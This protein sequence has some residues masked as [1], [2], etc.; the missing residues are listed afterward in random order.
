MSGFPLPRLEDCSVPLNNPRYTRSYGDNYID[1][2]IVGHPGDI[3]VNSFVQKAAYYVPNRPLLKQ[4]LKFH[5]G[6]KP[7]ER[8]GL[9]DLVVHI[10]LTDYATI[11]NYPG[12]EVFERGVYSL[13]GQYAKLFI[14]TDDP[15]DSEIIELAR[16][17]KG[18]IRRSSPKEDFYFLMNADYLM[19]SQSTFSWWAA[20][21]G[22]PKKLIVP[23]STKTSNAF[24]YAPTTVPHHDSVDLATGLIAVC[25]Q[26]TFITY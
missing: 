4:Y 26:T 11:G 3:V 21:L 9:S 16:V 5:V 6:D 24:W 2:I 18:H 17:Y 23:L 22:E 12:I 25:P 1:P 10:R 15:T 20:F 19:L 14:V 7:L 8:P 13:R